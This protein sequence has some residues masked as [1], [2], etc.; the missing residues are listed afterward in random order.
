MASGLAKIPMRETILARGAPLQPG[1]SLDCSFGAP[2]PLEDES[3]QDSPVGVKDK[4]PALVPL[5][6]QD[7]ARMLRPS[8]TPLSPQPSESCAGLR[9]AFHAF[10]IVAINV[11]RRLAS[12]R[13]VA[14]SELG[15]ST[16][17]R[18]RSCRKL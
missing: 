10:R 5:A 2:H 12:G 1:R 7:R 9:R 13:L 11:A 15:F 17:A 6:P 4:A 3:L 14:D 18:A 16:R 8:S